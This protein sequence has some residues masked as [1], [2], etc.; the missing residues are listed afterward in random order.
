MAVIKSGATSDQ[1]TVD[2]TSKA[3]RVTQYTSSGDE[4][5]VGEDAL[6]SISLSSLSATH[7]QHL[8]AFN[9]VGFTI[10]N[11]G[12]AA[13][14]LVAESTFDNVTWTSCVIIDITNNNSITTVSST[15]SYTIRFSGGT[16]AIRLKVS[17]YTSGTILGGMT[18]STA[19]SQNVVIRGYDNVLSVVNSTT[20]NQNAGVTFTGVF[21][22]DLLWV[23]T[24]M[25]CY[26]TQNLTI[27]FEQSIDGTNVSTSDTFYYRAGTINWSMVVQLMANY[28]RVIITNTGSIATTTLQYQSYNCPLSLNEPR[29]LTANGNKRVEIPDKST[30]RVSL[31]AFSPIAGNTISLA[32]SATKTVRVTR[33]AFTLQSADN[34]FDSIEVQVLKL[35]AISGGTSSTLTPIP[36]DSLNPTVSASAKSYTVAPTVT[37]LGA[38]SSRR[39]I[40]LPSG[41]NSGVIDM[42][43]FIY[44][45]SI[46]GTSPV[47][48]RGT[49]EAITINLSTIG[50]GA[51]TT[52]SG[53]IE[54]IEE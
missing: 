19:I 50:G 44:G 12:H 4:I 51:G 8:D 52:L 40:S 48:L 37:S 33:V 35:S 21:E 17:A 31:S 1:L 6:T 47:V 49:A 2:P 39:I 36:L 13:N 14:R 29:T 18:A 27:V 3:A 38:V 9:G 32:G 34:T 41:S 54:W 16:N 24:T 11:L 30:Y 15:G 42:E 43:E 23:S 26:A 7:E 22:P 10:T 53:S 28:H 20:A 25:S 45:N 46:S 5:T